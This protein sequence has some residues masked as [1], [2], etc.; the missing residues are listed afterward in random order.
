[1]TGLRLIAPD[2]GL[3]GGRIGRT[4]EIPRRPSLFVNAFTCVRWFAVQADDLHGRHP[5]RQPGSRSIVDR[6]P[7]ERCTAHS[8]ETFQT[9]SEQ[10]RAVTTSGL[11]AARPTQVRPAA[12]HVPRHGRGK[13]DRHETS[14]GH[15]GARR[16]RSAGSVRRGSRSHH[17]Q[18][19]QP[20]VLRVRPDVDGCA[21]QHHPR[22]HRAQGLPCRR[23]QGRVELSRGQGCHGSRWR[24]RDPGSAW[25]RRRDRC[26]RPGR[27]RGSRRRG[28]R[29][30]IT[31]HRRPRSD[32]R[33][34]RPGPGRRGR[35]AGRHRP[36]GSAGLARC[37]RGAGPAG[38]DRAH[39]TDR[40]RRTARATRNRRR[41]RSN[42]PAGTAGTQ[43]ET[44][45]AVGASRN[46]VSDGVERPRRCL[47][48]EPR[49]ATDPTS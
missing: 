13:G 3:R 24:A 25:T 29:A 17:L 8:Q 21:L 48:G 39:R 11:S 9:V 32:R 22:T 7:P 44:G 33:D 6:E 10:P 36:A 37:G 19:G 12:R 49:P 35:R 46:V 15:R 38:R 20:R 40:G 47:V 34:R 27:R 26:N 16:H 31:G 43:T 2:A 30:G 5:R 41:H 28:R 18:P 45:P 1:M 42:R 14:P 4:D 23:P